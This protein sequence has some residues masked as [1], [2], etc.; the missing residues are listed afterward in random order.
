M[1]FIA[2]YVTH[3][4]EEEGKRIGDHLLHKRLIACYNLFPMESA[5][6]WHGKIDRAN[7]VVTLLKTRKE[8]WEKIQTEIKKLHLYET[9][10]MMK[11]E[12]EA[13][14]EYEKWLMDTTK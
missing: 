1:S 9:P 13:N 6:W 14:A 7:E 5:F 3:P 2:I 10:C 4:S 12:M 8:H 11:F